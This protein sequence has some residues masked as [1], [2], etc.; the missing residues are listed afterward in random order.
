MLFLLAITALAVRSLNDW[1]TWWGYPLLA[2]GLI[3]LSLSAMSGLL[4]A[5][6]FQLFIAPVL[7]GALP[8]EIVGVF[9]D[10]MAAIVRNALRPSLLLAGIMAW[11]G[12]VMVAFIFLLRK[13]FQKDPTYGS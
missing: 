7:P 8:P 13:R 3:S 10:L 9:R 4:A 11:I 6:T 1:L 12:L 2:A 5:G